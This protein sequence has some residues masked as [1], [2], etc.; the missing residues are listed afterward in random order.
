MVKKEI[1][2]EM[3]NSGASYSKIANELNMSINTIKSIIKRSKEEK[4]YCKECG[5]K[6]KLVPKH[7]KKM[8]CSD[9]CRIAYWKK[10]NKSQIEGVCKYCGKSIFYYPSK[11]R[12]FCS[13]DCYLKFVKGERYGK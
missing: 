9:K 1:I 7:K 10:N 11:S 6:L 3:K 5:A 12:C 13:R 2:I 4:H 8:F